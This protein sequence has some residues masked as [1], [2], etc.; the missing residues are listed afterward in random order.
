MN[1]P[2][3]G[4]IHGHGFYGGVCVCVCVSGGR[5]PQQTSSLPRTVGPSVRQTRRSTVG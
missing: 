1:T 3:Q 5:Y 2:S 4:Q